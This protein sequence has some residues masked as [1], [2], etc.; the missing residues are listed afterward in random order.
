MERF[1]DL[2]QGQTALIVTHR[3]TTAMQA[4]VIH[5]MADGRVVESGS[6]AE[7]LAQGGRYA[8]SWRQQMREAPATPPVSAGGEFGAVYGPEVMVAE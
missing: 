7:L 6:H 5:V 2:V 8:T 1:R 3:F 4:D